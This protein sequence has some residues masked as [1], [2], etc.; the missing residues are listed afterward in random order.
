MREASLNLQEDSRVSKR[1]SCKVLLDSLLLDTPA[2]AQKQLISTKGSRIH[3]IRV[4]CKVP[5]RGTIL[6]RAH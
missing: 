3:D 1:L 5:L 4:I 6:L 2:L